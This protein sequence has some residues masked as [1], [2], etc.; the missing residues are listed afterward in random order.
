LVR[1]HVKGWKDRAV[2]ELEEGT[3][4]AIDFEKIH[5][6]ARSKEGLIPVVLQHADT[7]DVLFVGYANDRALAETLASRRAVLWSASRDELWR[8]GATSGDELE[9]VEVRVNCEQNALV[10]VVRPVAGGVCHTRD[11]AG[12]TRRTCFYRRLRVPDRLEFLAGF[13]PAE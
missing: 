13:A 12:A 9:L 6:A 2:N 5:R 1:R 7:K 4:A 10:Y 11:G 3:V 8:K